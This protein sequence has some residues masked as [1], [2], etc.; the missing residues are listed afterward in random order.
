MRNLYVQFAM[1]VIITGFF[2]LFLRNFDLNFAN[3]QQ[4]PEITK[5]ELEEEI[6][7]QTVYYDEKFQEYLSNFEDW[8]NPPSE[9]VKEEEN[10]N[11]Y[12]VNSSILF[13]FI[14]I[15]GMVTIFK[16]FIRDRWF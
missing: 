14:F 16:L 6:I 8:K 3:Y 2:I 11:T 15:F 7:N 9:I 4:N 5:V 1:L 10:I 13:I 12:K